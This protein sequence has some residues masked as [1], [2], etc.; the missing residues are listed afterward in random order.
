MYKI[1]DEKIVLFTQAFNLLNEIEVKGIMNIN[2]LG[3][4]ATM[5][6]QFFESLEKEENNSMEQKEVKK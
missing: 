5:F 6:R 3:N 2:A 4:S 1:S